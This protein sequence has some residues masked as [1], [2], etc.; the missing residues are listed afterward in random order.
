MKSNSVDLSTTLSSLRSL[1]GIGC[2]EWYRNDE[3]DWYVLEIL[4]YLNKSLILSGACTIL[5]RLQEFTSLYEEGTDMIIEDRVAALE[6]RVG[7]DT[8]VEGYRSDLF[9]LAWGILMSTMYKTLS[10]NY[11]GVFDSTSSS[12]DCH[13]ICNDCTGSLGVTDSLG[14]SGS[15]QSSNYYGNCGCNK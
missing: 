12:G 9:I 5:Q 8:S 13:D 14:G 4:K 3:L 15:W 10:I 11:A 7:I 2:I 1:F 6:F